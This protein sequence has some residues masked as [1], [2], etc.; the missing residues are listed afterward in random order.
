[1]KQRAFRQIMTGYVLL[2]KAR[3]QVRGQAA[4]SMYYTV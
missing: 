4:I 1:M 2:K 3:P